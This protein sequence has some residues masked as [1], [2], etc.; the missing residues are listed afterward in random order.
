MPE[1]VC[2][3]CGGTDFYKEVGFYYCSGCQIQSQDI[4]EYAHDIE[5]TR[6]TDAQG[7]KKGRKVH[8]DKTPKADNKITSWEC[9]NYILLGLTEELIN[10]GAN[11][12]I[13]PIV[14]ILWLRYLEKMEVFKRGENALPKLQGVNSE[15]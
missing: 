5:Y 7:R 11:K 8:S 9:Y 3:H 1:I 13:K 15:L 4:Q 2:D 6:T 14:R 12:E 10:L